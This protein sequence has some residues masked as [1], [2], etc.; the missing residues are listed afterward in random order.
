MSMS[1]YNV[2]D[3]VQKGL[4]YGLA[5]VGGFWLGNQL[6]VPVARASP[7]LKAEMATAI[8]F[9]GVIG[10]VAVAQQ[11]YKPLW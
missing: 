9:L 3:M 10:G 5:G 4:V 11:N 6:A 8:P 1:S 2:K 7:V